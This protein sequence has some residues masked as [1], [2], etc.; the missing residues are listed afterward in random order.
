M[1]GD[2][3]KID[4]T[5]QAFMRDPLPTLTRLRQAGPA[6]RVKLPFLGTT[7]IA[8]THEAVSE[9][10]K[11]E[12]TFVRNPRNAGKRLFAGMPWWIPPTLR[13]LAE[14]MLSH[15]DPDHRRLRRLVDQAF[16]RHSVE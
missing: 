9:V 16:N 6:V 5:S 10:L 2:F 1:A 8:T 3:L 15:D 14:N 11:D 4:L 13:I 7:W 12:Q